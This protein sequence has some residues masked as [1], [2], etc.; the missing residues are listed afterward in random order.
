M[1]DRWNDI[2][3]EP[4]AIGGASAV[5]ATFLGL[6]YLV[7][8]GAP[9]R[10]VVV[11]LAALV[12]GLV[13]VGGVDKAALLERRASGLAVVVLGTSLLAT[14]LFGA[15]ADGASRWIWIGP[16]SVQVSLVLLPFMLV[17]FAGRRDL[18]GT[19][20]IAL[21]ALALVIQPDRAM[22]GVLALGLA[23]LATARRDMFTVTALLAALAAFAVTLLRPDAL[24]AAPFVDQVL[25][26]AFSV[27][28][29]TGASTLV[30]A[31][32]LVLPAV[33]G[34]RRDP[35]DD[36][37]GRVFGAVWIGCIAAAALGNYPTPVVGY[38][39][40][41]I[42]GYVL[43]L[44]VFPPRIAAGKSSIAGRSGGAEAQA[45]PMERR[46]VVALDH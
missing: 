2:L 27:N 46:S 25:F 31:G 19:A 12:L 43:S 34:Q 11:N 32:L 28:P 37:P 29:L 26:T 20:G 6:F 17:C 21:A 8:A 22:A 1:T 23:A 24:P 14:A 36:G 10:Y 5:A 45:D 16:L 42:L 38:G 3:R 44:A 15:S 35:S 9:A 13:A 33:A 40:S 7:A 18:A 39:G 4:R 30:G 41:A